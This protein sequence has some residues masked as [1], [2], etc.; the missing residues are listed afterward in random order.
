MS[1]LWQDK[2]PKKEV[3]VSTITTAAATY[4]VW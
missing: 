2:A 1:W 4:D 3:Q